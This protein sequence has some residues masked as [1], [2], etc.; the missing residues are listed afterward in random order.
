MV[1]LLQRLLPLQQGV[2]VD[3]G[4]NKGDTLMVVKALERDRSCVCIEPNPNAVFYI[5]QLIDANRFEK[6]QVIAAGV[7]SETRLIP[8]RFPGQAGLSTSPAAS[9]ILRFDTKAD[10]EEVLVPCF[11]L[12]EIMRSVGDVRVGFVKIDAEG[13]EREVIDGMQSLIQRWQPL[14]IFEALPTI[15]HPSCE[16]RQ[17]EVVGALE[18]HEYDVFRILRNGGSLPGLAPVVTC[19]FLSADKHFDYIA[20]P[21]DITKRL[22]GAYEASVS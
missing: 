9:L 19:G 16:Q 3:V 13:A 4:A 8:L 22:L 18:S 15:T 1:G 14:I 2:F 7:F 5:N 11:Q 20:V 6:C 17:R 21:R 12:D 10:V